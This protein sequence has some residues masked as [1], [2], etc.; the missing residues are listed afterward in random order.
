MSIRH[1]R[2]WSHGR[3]KAV[4]QLSLIHTPPSH[5]TTSTDDNLADRPTDRPLGGLGGNTVRRAQCTAMYVLCATESPQGCSTPSFPKSAC[6]SVGNAGDV[7]V[8]R[9][10]VGTDG[11]DGRAYRYRRRTKRPA[12]DGSC[13]HMLPMCFGCGGEII[14]WQN[15]VA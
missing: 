12:G 8:A 3:S 11:R 6:L 5:S 15:G 9:D 1:V 2:P 10:P 4:S 7:A 13:S 14:H